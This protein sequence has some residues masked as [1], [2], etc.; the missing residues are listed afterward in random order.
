MSAGRPGLEL[1]TYAHLMPESQYM[2]AIA[3]YLPWVFSVL[4]IAV[5]VYGVHRYTKLS[6]ALTSL[7]TTHTSL[8]DAYATAQA[9][10]ARSQEEA[11]SLARS[12]Q[13][14]R[15]ST[16]ALN[17]EVNDIERTVNTLQRLAETDPEL[18]QKYSKVYFLNEHYIPSG[19]TQIPDEYVFP[20][21]TTESVHDDVWSYLK[22]LIK[23]AEED[24]IQLKVISG[25]RSYSQQASL[26]A[27]YRV[28]YGSGANTFSADQGYSEH[29]LGTTVDFTTEKIGSTFAGFEK[30]GEYAWL[31][32]NAYK[33]GFI[34]SYPAN[35]RYY[36]FEPWHWRFV[37]E[38]L[39]DTL[40]DED[41]SF[42]DLDQRT[43]DQH[44]ADIFQ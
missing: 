20:K 44:L 31:Q 19:L 40:H 22:D 11:V 37:G 8:E 30:S 6:N 38:K 9:E 42:Y 15:A 13:K 2:S 25:Y 4:L 17:D 3:K 12:L 28:T 7:E 34:L 23:D 36:Q 26:K 32:K 24:G 16:T 29:Q 33:Y 18:L 27:S 14:E 43:I 35:N 21:G 10:L 39:A 1:R 5:L 41:T